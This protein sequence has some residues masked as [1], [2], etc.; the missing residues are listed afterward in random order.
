MSDLPNNGDF[1]LWIC[2]MWCAEYVYWKWAH[3]L[4]RAENLDWKHQEWIR[5][6]DGD[7]FEEW[8]GFLESQLNQYPFEKVNEIFKQTLHLEKDFF[9]ACYEA[10]T[11]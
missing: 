3:D 4:P 2:H 8:C 5:L 1:G 7:H 10:A 11:K 6:H 9:D